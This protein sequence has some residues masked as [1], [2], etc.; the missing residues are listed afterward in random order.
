MYTDKKD[1]AKDKSAN[2]LQPVPITAID[3]KI[4]DWLCLDLRY[5]CLSVVNPPPHHLPVVSTTESN[6]TVPN[7]GHGLLAHV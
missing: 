4:V 6:H 5:R 2:K 1:Q 7:A 3:C